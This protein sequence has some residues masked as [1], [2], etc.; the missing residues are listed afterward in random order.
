MIV[1]VLT[2]VPRGGVVS[3]LAVT[4]VVACFI[5]KKEVVVPAVIVLVLASSLSK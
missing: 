1:H 2:H 5:G 3:I 4:H